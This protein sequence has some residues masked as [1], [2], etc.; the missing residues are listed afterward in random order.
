MVW[1]VEAKKVRL[2]FLPIIGMFECR[3]DRAPLGENA[4]NQ[5]GNNQEEQ[6]DKDALSSLIAVLL[7]HIAGVTGDIALDK[8]RDIDDGGDNSSSQERRTAEHDTFASHEATNKAEHAIDDV[9]EAT[10]SQGEIGKRSCGL[11]VYLI[12]KCGNA[13][14]SKRDTDNYSNDTNNQ[15]HSERLRGGVRRRSVGQVVATVVVRRSVAHRSYISSGVW[16]L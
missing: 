6:R 16:Y 1:R 4:T 13:E 10:Q 3:T 5:A 15:A 12:V 7:L 8:T 14:K 11:L 9:A 2:F